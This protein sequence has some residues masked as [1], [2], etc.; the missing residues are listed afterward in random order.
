MSSVPFC[1]L[2]FLALQ[3]VAR[4]ATLHLPRQL[5]STPSTSA[6]FP[7]SIPISTA[8]PT[9]IPQPLHPLQAN[10]STV[11][12]SSLHPGAAPHDAVLTDHLGSNTTF[13]ASS[14]SE[15]GSGA[16]LDTEEEEEEE[17]GQG[18]EVDGAAAATIKKLGNANPGSG[19]GERLN[20]QL[21]KVAAVAVVA[22][23]LM[24]LSL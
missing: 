9:T 11:S 13:T 17:E 18:R 2:F 22:V 10:I 19:E 8:N 20:V 15:G 4:A 6:D 12:F 14:E 24:I 21:G 16:K 7:P 5:A 1:I 23:L 3:S